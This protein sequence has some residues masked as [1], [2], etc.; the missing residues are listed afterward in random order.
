MRTTTRFSCLTAVLV[1]T[2]ANVAIGQTHLPSDTTGVASRPAARTDSSYSG[3]E[4]DFRIG[5]SVYLRSSKTLIGKIVAIDPDHSFPPSF[6]RTR[7]KG[8][9][10]KRK[11]GPLGW[12]PIDG[13]LR[14]YVVK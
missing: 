11:D 14:I 1:L 2:S 9:L 4:K 8:V 3:E 13:A 7:A 10:I 5:K 12:L 6:G